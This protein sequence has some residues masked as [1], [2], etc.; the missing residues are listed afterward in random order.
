[1]GVGVGVS[2]HGSEAVACL[3]ACIEHFGVFHCHTFGFSIG[4]EKLSLGFVEAKM[5]QRDRERSSATLP[6][7]SYQD[8]STDSICRRGSSTIRYLF[9]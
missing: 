7:A 5:T 3:L 6:L 8:I 2:V 4:L 1:V 9:N